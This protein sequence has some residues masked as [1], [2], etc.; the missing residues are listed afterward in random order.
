VQSDRL[1]GM[2]I[3]FVCR[4]N[5]GRSQIAEM[6]FNKYAN[7]GHHAFSAGTWVRD[8][9]G[10]SMHGRKLHEFESAKE[11]IFSLQEIGIDLNENKR[12]Q[13]NEQM[14][15]DADIIVVMAEEHTIPEFL[16]NSHKVRYWEVEDPKGMD[17]GDT[18]KIQEQISKLVD[19][20]LDELQS[21]NV[22]M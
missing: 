6:V 18:N 2:K 11:V 1:I 21:T 17:Q 5:V 20:L 9:S 15:E 14:V 8:K 3:L 19:K 22:G 10:E 7:A 12:D 4:G 16:K 13:I